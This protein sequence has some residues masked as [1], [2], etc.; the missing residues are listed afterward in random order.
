MQAEYL[1][2]AQAAE[3]AGVS[4]TTISR[5]CSAG[6]LRHTK[7]GRRVMVD[8]ESLR[9]LYGLTQGIK[10]ARPAK[11]D[12]NRVLFR[13]Y[14]RKW[15]E[16]ERKWRAAEH[17]N[18]ELLKLAREVRDDQSGHAAG[19]AQHV[20][21]LYREINAKNLAIGSAEIRLAIAEELNTQQHE[22]IQDLSLQNAKLHDHKRAAS[23]DELLAY[24]DAL[25]ESQAENQ[26]LRK[27]RDNAKNPQFAK[28]KTQEKQEETM[29]QM[30]HR[31]YWKWSMSI[32]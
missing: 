6:K 5:A 7:K 24:Q 1:A 17:H 18:T 9:E 31:H 4:R 16:T 21:G 14:Y 20:A 30:R 32:T 25:R 13:H 28:P 26:A 3:M 29:Q 19:M 27:N 11:I 10:D 15:R 22:K 8:P 2:M 23:R 12:S